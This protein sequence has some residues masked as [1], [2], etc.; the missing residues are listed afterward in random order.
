[1]KGR[2]LAVVCLM[3][4]ATLLAACGK[5]ETSAPADAGAATSGP[6]A[7]SSAAAAPGM[8]LGVAVYPGAEMVRAPH[9]LGGDASGS[10]MDSAF[11]SADKS[12]KVAAFY[13][14][15]L[16]KAFQDQV[17]ETPMGEGMV[18]LQG[19][20]AEKGA[21]AQ[22]IVR[23]DDSGSGTVFSIRSLVRAK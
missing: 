11:K 2:N 3:G 21:N 4:A 19:G 17:A 9:E 5:S 16:K 7:A 15:E 18:Q 12:D 8:V 22:I 1:M 20:N 23:T 14:E 10:M 6:A 13:R